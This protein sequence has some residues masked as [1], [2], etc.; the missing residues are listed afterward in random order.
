MHK[1]DANGDN[2]RQRTRISRQ[3]RARWICR[4]CVAD[5]RYKVGTGVHV[6]KED[7]HHD[8]NSGVLRRS[9]TVISYARE[10]NET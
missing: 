4:D 3:N 7:M 8:V 10:R 9:G 5:D 2:A 1:F 6:I